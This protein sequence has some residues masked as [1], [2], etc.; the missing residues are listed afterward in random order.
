MPAPGY[1][2]DMDSAS[3]PESPNSTQT[4]LVL[5]ASGYVGGRL[6]PELLDGGHRVRC[7]TRNPKTLVGRPWSAAVDVHEADLLEQDSLGD[8]F[9]GIDT[10]Y[11][12]VHSLGTGPGFEERERRCAA[13][14]REAAEV[15]GVRHIIYLSGLGEDDGSLS[16]HLRSRHEVG[17]ELAS[18]PTPVT[19][20]R[21]A[22]ILGSGSASFE[23]LR[24][25]VEILPMMVTPRW[26]QKTCCQPIAIVDVLA[27]LTD[28]LGRD[29]LD[30]VFE[31]GGADVVTYG[32]MMQAFAE[33][34]GLRSRVILPV[35]V[36]SPGLSA[37]WVDLVTTL[38]ASLAT[39][40]VLGLQNDVV[41]TDRPISS[42]IPRDVLDIRTALEAALSAVQD[43]DIPTRWAAVP[44][45]RSAAIPRPWD[46]D[47]SGGTVFDDTR[48]VPVNAPPA[49]VM[50]QVRRVGGDERWYGYNLLWS[51]RSTADAL[52]GGVGGRRGRRH[53]SELAVGDIVDAFVVQDLNDSRLLLRAEMKLPGYGWLEW[54]VRPSETT[55]DPA[56]S[57]LTLRA[58]FVPRGLTGRLYWFAV[59]PFHGLV[60]NRMLDEIRDRSE[61][62]ASLPSGR[63]SATSLSSR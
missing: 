19:E 56:T 10:V 54:L 17:R 44:T 57:K 63:R 14:T 42:E 51:L 1:V 6:I 27:Y 47:W 11:Y 62:A 31:I 52:I 41:V 50:D 34:A 4:V 59:L 29:D 39:E 21:A 60:F 45:A 22:V 13:N 25:L 18:G 5:G 9:A 38:P 8:V 55:N 28:V 23:M 3:K 30:G 49:M 2:S 40:L 26:V 37:K 48:S 46:P 58:R 43:L 53:P 32:E 15:A 61:S 33:V 20:L 7:V 35:P 36:L 12:L 16:P 24:G